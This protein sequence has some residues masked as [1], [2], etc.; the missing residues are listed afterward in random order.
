MWLKDRL[1]VSYDQLRACAGKTGGDNPGRGIRY[2]QALTHNSVTYPLDQ[3]YRHD[4]NI[5]VSTWIDGLG[6]KENEGDD[7]LLFYNSEALLNK[8]SSENLLEHFKKDN[9]KKFY[10]QKV[11]FSCKK[12][13]TGE[14]NKDSFFVINQK[15]VK[16]MGV[17][18]GHGLNGHLASCFTM[19]AIVEF[20]ENSKRFD[21]DFE[22]ATEA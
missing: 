10:D 15:K 9:R 1:N 16:I 17:F 2:T 7:K 3:M 22:R 18:D 11:Q 6:Y 13:Q 20:I 19:S 4:P 21:V 12:G 8:G 14:R 5:L